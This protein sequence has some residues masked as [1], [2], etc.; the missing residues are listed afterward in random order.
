M[1]KL[2]ISGYLIA[3]TIFVNGQANTAGTVHVGA[4][5]G[6]LLGGARI[7]TNLP[8]VKDDGISVGARFHPG[9][10][11]QYSFHNMLSAGIYLR[12]ESAGYIS[13]LEDEYGNSYDRTFTA[14]GLGVGA[15]LKFYFLNKDKFLMYLAPSLGFAKSNDNDDFTDDS[16]YNSYE[17][18]GDGKS[19]GT[20]FGLTFGFNWYWA[21][22]IGMSLDVG[23]NRVSMKGEFDNITPSA[24]SDYTVKGVNFVFG[25]GLVSKFGGN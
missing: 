12:S 15:E 6:V 25:L 5:F 1:K 7:E 13:T 22:F 24:Y 8:Y 21:K 19:T 9:I 10:R 11:A 17:G 2:L 16:Y 14:R 18:G 4:G 20:E 23:V 3:A